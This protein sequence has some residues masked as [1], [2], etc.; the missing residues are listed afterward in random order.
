MCQSIAAGG[1]GFREIC[2]FSLALLAKHG[3]RI[4]TRPA[5]LLSRILK[6]IYFSSSSFG[7]AGIGSCLSLTLHGIC[8]VRPLL[9]E[10]HDESG[11]GSGGGGSNLRVNS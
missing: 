2:E 9:K 8:A 11:K 6:A 5:S 4:L 7:E 3:W 1:L 10:G